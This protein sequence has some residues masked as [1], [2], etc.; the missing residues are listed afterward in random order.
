MDKNATP[1]RAPRGGINEDR[2]VWSAQGFMKVV[3]PVFPWLSIT[4][5]STL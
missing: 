1:W 2:I 5:T 3:A 4:V